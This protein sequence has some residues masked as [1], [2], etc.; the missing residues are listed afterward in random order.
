MQTQPKRPAFKGT[1]RREIDPSREGLVRLEPLPG[2]GSLPLLAWSEVDG[3]D[4]AAWMTRNRGDIE[5]RL[6]AHGGILFRGFGVG[7]P[8]ELDRI[9]R[10]VSGE[11]LEY[12]YR[13]TP[14]TRVQGEIYTSTE[15]PADQ[16]IPLHNE[17]SYT[18][19]WPRKIFFCC[20]VAAPVGG[21]TPIADSRGVY[22]RIDPEIR[23]K[24]A[25][26]GVTY[27]RNYG[28]GIDLPWQD[29]FQTS[30]REAVEELCRRAGIEFE[31]RGEDE[32]RTRQTCQAVTV[33][34][35]TGEPVW[36]NQAHLF[37]VSGLPNALRESLLST[38]AEEDLPRNALYGDGTPFE[39]EVLAAIRA[40]YEAE[41][42][43]FP[44]QEGDVLLLDNV[45]VAHG[46]R[47]FQGPR[48][49]LVGMSE[50]GGAAV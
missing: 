2:G 3:V 24:L 12:T 49:V 16:S 7:T 43:E 29:V 30:D 22:R 50:P 13:S 45:L 41:T 8:E 23:E 4:L 21:E 32:L 31:W 9:V 6:S 46:R 19:S 11:T 37:H 33:H 10:A 26:L 18:R 17:M 14:R 47:P 44:W 1:Q 40:A 36:F 48:R 34:P 35:G 39:P 27:V 28:S 20:A 15:Y 25:R 5:A 38:F 42:M